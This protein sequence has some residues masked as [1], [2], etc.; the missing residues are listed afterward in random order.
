MRRNGTSRRTR[1]TS[2]AAAAAVA[3]ATLVATATVGA[4]SASAYADVQTGVFSTGSR[5]P[6]T[7]WGQWTGKDV[8]VTTAFLPDATWSDI[9]S[10]QW[11]V[12]LYSGGYHR[13][14][15]AVP[16]LPETSGV[17]IQQGATGQYNTYFKQLAELLVKNNQ[18]NAILRVGWEFN[19]DS[20]QWSAK[21]DPASWIAY[22]R[23]IV[24]TM[25]SVPGANFSF[26]WSP[27][28]GNNMGQ[29][30]SATAYPGDAYVDIVGQSLYD[31]SQSFRPD[32]YVERWANMYNQA[33]GLK[34]LAEF[35]KAHGKRIAFSEW[36]LTKSCD[37]WD[38]GDDTYFVQKLHDYIANNDVAYESYFNK[39]VTD[40][41][42]HALNTGNFPKAAALYQKLWVGGFA[43]TATPVTTGTAATSTTLI[44]VRVDAD[45]NSTKYDLNGANLQGANYIDVN[46]PKSSTRAVYFYLDKAA[47]G[48]PSKTESTAPYDFGGTSPISPTAL[49][50]D[51]STW[52][53]GTHTMTVVVSRYNLPSITQTATFTVG[54]TTVG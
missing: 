36:G 17:S 35:G 31:H 15:W 4:S 14:A 49:P 22:W 44:R 48:T 23:Q 3:G 40:C 50:T 54:G 26:N 34:W 16:M 5:G 11:G 43:P 10:W 45:V 12:G 18:G 39:D 47:T 21:K 8:A 9:S 2:L 37:G 25:R 13:M 6:V 33:G 27:G 7:E 53:P 1:L 46:V 30:D 42:K 29:F 24:T 28:S 20:F 38:S 41:E 32:Q 19:S 52:T 51:V